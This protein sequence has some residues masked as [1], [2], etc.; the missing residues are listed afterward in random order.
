[1]SFSGSGTSATTPALVQQEWELTLIAA[2][3]SN[4]DP[5]VFD[6]TTTGNGTDTIRYIKVWSSDPDRDVT[7]NIG[8]IS[9][10][11]KTVKQVTLDTVGG[12]NTADDGYTIVNALATD[13]LGPTAWNV[14]SLGAVSATN[15]TAPLTLATHAT[16]AAKIG[17]VFLN[18]NWTG[19]ITFAS[20]TQGSIED[21]FVGKFGTI[22]PN[23][24]VTV[25]MPGN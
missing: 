5:A 7:I 9:H 23:V 3:T 10:K 25:Q 22:S 20:S 2:N 18:G 17:S 16:K 13:D 11:L 21:F 8:T 4:N 15:W 1:M 12:G 6:V 14:H 24:P 19:N